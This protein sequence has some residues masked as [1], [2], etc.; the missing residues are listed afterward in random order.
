MKILIYTDNHFCQYSSIVRGRDEDFSIRIKNQILSV[1]WA[2]RLAEEKGCQMIAHLG[3]FFDK[4]EANSEE[5]TG[6]KHIKWANIPHK[7]IVGNHEMG[8]ADLRFNSMNLL[9]KVGEVICEPKLECGFSYE[10]IYLPYILETNRQP[11]ESYINTLHAGIFTTQEVKHTIILSHNDI[12]GIR[13]GQYLSTAGFDVKEITENCDL[14]LNGHLH[15]Q[16]QINSKIL[17]IGNLTGQNFSE[18]A[19]KFSHCAVILDTDTLQTELINNPYALNFYKFTIEN[20]NDFEKLAICKDYSV[21]SI[22]TYQSMVDKL[23]VELAKNAK[24]INYRIITL[25]EVTVTA[26]QDIKQILKL[27]HIEQFKNYIME[28]VEKTE[29]LNEELSLIN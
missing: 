3:D 26:K 18:D 25:P 22:K 9:A 13:Y 27:N 14:Y 21:L 20:E 19:E 4:A 10:I 16:Q 7:F 29:L 5:I 12:S 15:N 24:V 23:K 6:L 17:N 28:N 1:N 2:E 11:L 8:S